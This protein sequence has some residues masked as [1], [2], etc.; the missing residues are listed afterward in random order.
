MRGQQWFKE[1]SEELEQRHRGK[2][3]HRGFGRTPSPRHEPWHCGEG[4]WLQG[5]CTMS[6]Q[7]SGSYSEPSSLSYDT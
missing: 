7:E 5:G 1:H 6:W 4:P 2:Q 3:A